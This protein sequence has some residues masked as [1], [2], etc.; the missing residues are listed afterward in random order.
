M[1]FYSGNVEPDKLMAGRYELIKCKTCSLI[2]QR[3]V[4]NND[5]LQ[6]LYR[7]ELGDGSFESLERRRDFESRR[8]YAYAIEQLIKHFG[9]HPARIR[10]LDYGAGYGLWLNMAAAYGCRTSAAELAKGLVRA[11]EEH[12]EI[13]DRNR[14]PQASFDYINTE[15]VFEHLVEPRQVLADLAAALKPGG[16]LRISVPNG[17]NIP[18]LLKNPDWSA[19]K[20]SAKSL[21]AIAPLEHINCYNYS[22]LVSLGATSAL[23]PFHYPLRQF[24]DPWERA[25]F[26]LSAFYH[27]IR[28]A[29]GT[30][31]LFQ[32]ES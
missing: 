11:L 30:M 27:T 26:I 14:L 18:Q 8:A 31:L 16:I 21:N 22:A 25:R 29:S 13:V 7:R 19:P 9:L 2:F 5:L 23:R 17:S 32:K 20:G 28:H 15:Q 24:L 10:V 3:Q 4:P 6:Q 1:G 12:H